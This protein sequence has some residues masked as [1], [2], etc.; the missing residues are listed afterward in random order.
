LFSDQVATAN[1]AKIAAPNE[2]LPSMDLTAMYQRLDW[3]TAEGQQRRAA[4][5]KWEALVPDA[6]PPASIFGL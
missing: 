4:A 1:A 3:K 2:M 6:I 5:E